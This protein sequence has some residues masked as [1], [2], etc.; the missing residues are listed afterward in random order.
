MRQ[1]FP[2]LL[3]L[4]L[5]AG[6]AGCDQTTPVEPA[7]SATLGEPDF[8]RVHVHATQII[9]LEGGFSGINPCTGEETVINGEIVIRTNLSG[10]EGGF[11]HVE[12]T[13]EVLGTG[14]GVT[15]GTR[16]TLKES[17]HH[18]FNSPSGPA[19]QYT[20]TEHDMIHVNAQGAAGNYVDDA[21]FH[22]TV[23]PTGITVEVEKGSVTC[24]G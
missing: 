6:L 5:V 13:T 4:G 10:D 9:P 19:P 14:V 2:Y 3:C 11:F 8:S 24:R 15:T 18:S 17:F 20:V 7:A 22:F 16:Y 1:A 23:T 21:L 12:E